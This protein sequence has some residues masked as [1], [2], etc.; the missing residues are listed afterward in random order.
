MS[1]KQVA[2]ITGS[3]GGIGRGIVERFVAEG[4]KVIATSRNPG[5]RT[6]D[7]VFPIAADLGDADS[8]RRLV[9]EAIGEE[10]RIDYLVNNAGICPFGTVVDTSVDTWSQTLATNVTSA[11][12]CAKY[13]L[14]HLE[15]SPAG[16]VVNIASID[17]LL[18][19]HGLAV[20][21][22]SKAAM[23]GL[24]RGIAL[25]HGRAGVRCN[26]VCPGYIDTGMTE[27][28]LVEAEDPGQHRADI[29]SAHPVGR[30]GTPDDV[31]ALTWW[32]CSDEAGFVTGQ[33]YVT[34]GGLTAGLQPLLPNS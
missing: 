21:S 17:G 33:T 23:I 3:S 19:E 8:V 12:L 9:D 27:K 6:S 24:T 1:S 28:F 29:A 11:F 32:L 10:G 7:S 18:G 13:S 22:A 26:A 15:R 4:V 30:L 31:A 16:A 14:P 20:Y 5:P 25:D 34:D 2:L